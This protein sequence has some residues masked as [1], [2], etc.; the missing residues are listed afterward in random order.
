[1]C[2]GPDKVRFCSDACVLR[3]LFGF[4]GG[5]NETDGSAL[6]LEILKDQEECETI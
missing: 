3:L 6:I 2:E 1:M 5:M 4:N